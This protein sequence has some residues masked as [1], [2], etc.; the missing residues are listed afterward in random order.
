MFDHVTIRVSDR[1]ASELFYDELLAVLGV[2]KT[3]SDERPEWDD[4]SLARG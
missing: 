3:H 2:A 1:E 4:F